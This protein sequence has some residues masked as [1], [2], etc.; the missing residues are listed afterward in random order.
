MNKLIRKL[1]ELL[2]PLFSSVADLKNANKNDIITCTVLCTRA[3]IYTKGIEVMK[4]LKKKKYNELSSLI[5]RIVKL[6]SIHRNQLYK[7][8]KKTQVCL[9]NFVFLKDLKTLFLGIQ[10][11][12]GNKLN[13]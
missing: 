5:S 11:C 2:D 4:L 6:I 13:Q 1:P 3:K 7:L 12:F 10:V 9:K 8:T